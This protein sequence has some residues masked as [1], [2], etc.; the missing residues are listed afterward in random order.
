MSDQLAT[1]T[2]P[3]RWYLLELVFYKKNCMLI[4]KA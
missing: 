2:R 1:S 4:E 3:L